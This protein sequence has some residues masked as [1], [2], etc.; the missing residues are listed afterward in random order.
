MNYATQYHTRYNPNLQQEET[1][2]TTPTIGR[3]YSISKATQRP[4]RNTKRQ[5]TVSSNR[6]TTNGFLKT[7]FLPKLQENEQ[8]IKLPRKEVE[9]IETDFYTSLSQLEKHYSISVLETKKYSYPYNLS[10][11]CWNVE[12]KLKKYSKITCFNALQI[13]QQE[14]Q[15]TLR[16]TEKYETGNCLYYIP[17]VPLFRLLKNPQKQQSAQLLLSV[18]CYLYRVVGVPFY[19]E[20]DSY[21]YWLYDMITEWHCEE[22]DSEEK[23]KTLSELRKATCVGNYILRKIQSKENLIYWENR[24][25]NFQVKDD[26][27]KECISIATQFFNLYKKY[28]NRHLYLHINTDNQRDDDEEC[29]TMDKYISFIA[30]TNDSVFEELFNVVNND[31]GEYGAIEEPSLLKHFNGTDITTRNLEFENQIFKLI[32]QLCQLLT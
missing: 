8:Q 13:I 6:P 17:I 30:D 16:V 25:L 10:L 19:R 24:L 12:E 4:R 14:K 11:A 26:F 1:G 29:L 22:E 31:F 27:D 28:E 15:T 20:E 7:T 9:Q 5:K 18:F 21:L 32:P 2:T 23:E 3:V